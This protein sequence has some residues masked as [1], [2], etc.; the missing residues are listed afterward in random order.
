MT[1]EIKYYKE[2]EYPLKWISAEELE[3]TP[4]QT[5]DRLEQE[6]RELKDNNNHLQVIIDDGRAEN[7]RFREE[8]K[9]L[10]EEVEARRKYS[11]AWNDKLQ[12][13]KYIKALEEIREILCEGRTFYDGYFDVPYEQLVRS[14][15]AIKKINEVLNE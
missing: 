6:N 5:I 3:K 12:T 14:D 4:Q 9:K 10:K 8:N 1:E 11:S 7:K 2:K 13:D 15:K